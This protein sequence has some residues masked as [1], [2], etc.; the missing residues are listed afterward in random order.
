MITSSDQIFQFTIHVCHVVISRAIKYWYCSQ[1]Q[2]MTRSEI[3]TASKRRHI[4]VN[5][6]ESRALSSAAHDEEGRS[7]QTRENSIETEIEPGWEKGVRTPS[8]RRSTTS[9]KG[10]SP[11]REGC[12]RKP[13]DESS[14]RSSSVHDDLDHEMEL[15]QRE[16]DVGS[17]PVV[18]TIIVEAVTTRRPLALP[19]LV[20]DCRMNQFSK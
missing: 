16:G 18:L 11:T 20:G 19:L 9:L 17:P 7:N 4:A 15:D 6:K 10:A 14:D 5:R 3:P 2:H 1:I 13:R 8:P 12:I